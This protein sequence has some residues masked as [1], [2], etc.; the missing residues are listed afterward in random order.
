MPS[1]GLA[2]VL[3]D[4]VGWEQC[5]VLVDT[6]HFFRTD[7]PWRALEALS[8]GQIA[9]VHINDGPLDA[10]ADL[11]HESRF[12]RLPVGAGAFPLTRFVAAL[13][14][15]SGPFSSEV[16][17]DAIRLRPVAEGARVVRAGIERGWPG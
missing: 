10:T 3:C 6:W 15:Y 16:L 1:Y 4:S 8:G 5:G 11:V 9:L 7:E 17:S 12:G 14:G 13:G 2:A